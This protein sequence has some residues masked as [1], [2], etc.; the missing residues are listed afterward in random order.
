MELYIQDDDDEELEK[1][2]KQFQDDYGLLGWRVGSEWSFEV[3]GL[4]FEG[5]E[6][7]HESELEVEEV[8]SQ[9]LDHE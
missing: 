3:T 4:L 1:N 6:D 5:N 7:V 9:G 8:V 2:K